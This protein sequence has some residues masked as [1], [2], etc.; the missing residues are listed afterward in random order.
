M[1]AA[2]HTAPTASP[3]GTTVNATTGC[4]MPED[5]PAVGAKL[6]ANMSQPI[7]KGVAKWTDV[8]RKLTVRSPAVRPRVRWVGLGPNRGSHSARGH[9]FVAAGAPCRP[10]SRVSSGGCHWQVG[11]EV[12]VLEAQLNPEN[13]QIRCA[14][15]PPP[16]AAQRGASVADAAECRGGMRRGAEQAPARSSM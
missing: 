2:T 9:G 7:R 16:Q 5:A 11:E 6:K 15:P 12:E 3:E 10:G 4:E 13:G 14:N 1:S 8:V